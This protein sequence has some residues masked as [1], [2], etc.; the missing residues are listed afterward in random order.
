MKQ[1]II[2]TVKLKKRKKII[3]I[4]KKKIMKSEK[5]KKN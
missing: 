1:K 3:E 5:L 4:F 2:K